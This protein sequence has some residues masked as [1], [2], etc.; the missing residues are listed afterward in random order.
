MKTCNK[1]S[2]ISWVLLR[3][4]SRTSWIYR[5]SAIK[6]H[7][8]SCRNATPTSKSHGYSCRKATPRVPCT[9]RGC[10]ILHIIPPTGLVDFLRTHTRSTGYYLAGWHSDTWYT[11]PYSYRWYNITD[12]VNINVVV[13]LVTIYTYAL[14]SQ[15]SIVPLVTDKLPV[16]CVCA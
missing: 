10:V 12:L 5:W 13:Q 16:R 14:H 6:S 8:Y 11:R 2:T 9:H 3:S 15:R 4:K 7:G 1:I